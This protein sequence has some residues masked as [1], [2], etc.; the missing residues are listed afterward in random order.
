MYNW[1]TDLFV[2]FENRQRAQKRWAIMVKKNARSRFFA[3]ALSDNKN[4]VFTLDNKKDTC[5]AS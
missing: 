4:A 1:S 3:A 5:H 2:E